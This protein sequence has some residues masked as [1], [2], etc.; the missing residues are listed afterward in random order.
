[1]E[2]LTDIFSKK[3][4]LFLHFLVKKYGVFT[5]ENLRTFLQGKLTNF[6]QMKTYGLFTNE[7]LRTFLEGGGG[8]KAS[9]R[10]ERHKPP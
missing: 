4:G 5:N 8:G 9:A 1:M 3:Y 2:K 6:L 10:R 7:N